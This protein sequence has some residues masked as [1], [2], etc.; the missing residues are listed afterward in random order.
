MGSRASGIAYCPRNSRSRAV[1][2]AR[3]PQVGG[4]FGRSGP[5][6]AVRPLLS[7]HG[8]KIPNLGDLR[9]LW[10]ILKADARRKAGGHSGSKSPLGKSF[11]SLP[12]VLKDPVLGTSMRLSLSHQAASGLNWRRE[13]GN[14]GV[15]LVGWEGGI[16]APDKSYVSLPRTHYPLGETSPDCERTILPSATDTETSTGLLLRISSASGFSTRRWMTRLSGRAPKSGS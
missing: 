2:P 5:R 11:L 6:L 15:I 3:S 13:R 7:C 12:V 1:S 10:M 14:K 4:R 16:P 9:N 8:G